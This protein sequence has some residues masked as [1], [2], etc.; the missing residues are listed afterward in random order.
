MTHKREASCCRNATIRRWEE[1]RGRRRV[2]LL[3]R[4][5]GGVFLGPSGI[6]ARIAGREEKG[7]QRY[8]AYVPM[9]LESVATYGLVDSGNSVGTAMSY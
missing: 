2:C 5:G 1:R 6:L 7:E 3:G 8:K 9:Q 4:S